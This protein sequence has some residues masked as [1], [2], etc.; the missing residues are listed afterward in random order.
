MHWLYTRHVRSIWFNFK[1]SK[2]LK[3][4]KDY[5][6]KVNESVAAAVA[7]VAMIMMMTG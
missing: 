7:V 2:I 1:G 6:F 3:I 5:Y 4:I